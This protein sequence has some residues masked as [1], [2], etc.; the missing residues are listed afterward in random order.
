ML[1]RYP[2]L[3]SPQIEDRLKENHPALPL[4]HSKTVYNFVQLIRKKEGLEKQP[5]KEVRQYEN[6]AETG[7]G[8]QGQVDWGQYSMIKKGGGRQT[9]YFIVIVLS[10]S[11]QKYVYF[12]AIP[13]NTRLTIEAHNLAFTYFQGQ[14]RELLYDQDRV[15]MVDENLGDIILTKEFSRY[16]SGMDFKP[17]FCRKSDPESKGKVENVVQ[18]IKKNFLRGREF[19]DAGKLNS[20]SLDWLTR[21][22]NGKEHST[23]RKIPQEDWLIEKDYLLPLPT[24]LL[25]KSEPEYQTYKVRKDNTI[26]YR[27][28]YYTL[29][30]GTYQGDN[31]EVLI[32][33]EGDSLLI[34][35]M[36][37]RILTSHKLSL[38]K[39]QT[40]RNTDHRRDKS[41]GL[42]ILKEE[43]LSAY[44]QGGEMAEFVRLIQMDK[45]R[46]LRDN[47]QMIKRIQKKESEDLIKEGLGWCLLNKVYNAN[48]LRE[49]INHLKQE[50]AKKESMKGLLIESQTNHL[51]SSLAEWHTPGSSNINTYQQLFNHG[52]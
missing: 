46:Y 41:L 40:I 5:C 11:R 25:T 36:D 13:F 18:F 10:R 3:S 6:L 1:E 28:N 39:G 4:V 30:L 44:N 38:L 29:P 17:V 37:K 43:V 42:E 24:G 47:L 45:P 51:T 27:G 48:N 12:S 50:E 52:Q 2:Y 9:V 16:C 8:H 23:T 26:S 49:Y 22:G 14:P 20:S 34:F 19:E 33:V 31:T 35:D 32:R 15:L 7:Y 21:T